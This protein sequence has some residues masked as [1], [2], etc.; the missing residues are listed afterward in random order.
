M[1]T[2]RSRA[3]W[4][5]AVAI[6]IVAFASRPLPAA[7]SCEFTGIDRV[8]AVAD[9]H[10]AYDQF[11][12]ILR[13]A[14]V[15]DADAHWAGGATHLVQMGDLVDRGPD[16]RK[17]IDLV[18]RLE[19]EARTAGGQVH[20]LLGNHEVQRMLGDLR[21]TVP[22][23]YEAFA[24]AN[25]ERVRDDFLKTLN[26]SMGER[27]SARQNMPLGQVEMRVAFGR[28]GDYGRWLRQLPAVIIVNQ[29]A[30]THG[31]ISP[32]VA[33]LSCDAIN[34][35]VRKEL[36]SDLD[37]TR[38]T[39]LASLSAGADGPLWY[40]GLAQEPDTFAPQVEEMASKFH[41]RAIVVGHT[42]TPDN[43]VVV[44]FGGRVVQMDTAMQPAYVPHG[45]ASALE[46][47][48]GVATVIYVDRKDTLQLPPLAK[49]AIGDR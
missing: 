18:R 32:A 37:K 41:V 27:E 11:V 36:T 8:V 10:G 44:R 12:E 15:V 14:G 3:A 16:S 42:V 19:R 4:T 2:L 48:G 47:R 26:V 7:S 13:T 31:G 1:K 43:R 21:Y 49:S 40:R 35:R 9:V 23:E 30:F 22:G 24:S 25:S 33:A 39:P 46:I 5:A 34:D 20:A 38:A 28:D 17:A 6:A 29:I 45:R